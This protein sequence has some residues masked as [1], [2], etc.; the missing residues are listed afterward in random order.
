MSPSAAPAGG[1]PRRSS[2][3]HRIN[4]V[5]AALLRQ[6]DIDDL[7]WTLAEQVGSA[8]GVDDCVVYLLEDDRLVQ[9]A[10]HGPKSPARGQIANPI[11]IALGD[12]IT[13]LVARTGVSMLIRDTAD[14]ALYV[15]DMVSGRSELAVPIIDDGRVLGVIDSESVEVSAYTEADRALMQQIADLAA[16]RLSAARD[17]ASRHRALEQRIRE[18]EAALESKD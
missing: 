5:A 8:L 11:T 9:V 2:E 10:A 6:R 12:G 18:L 7:L 17:E 15:Q 16:P 3:V 4:L 14:D 1:T 13:G